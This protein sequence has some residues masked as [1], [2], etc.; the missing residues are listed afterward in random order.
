MHKQ[1]WDKMRHLGESAIFRACEFLT[2][3]LRLL[4]NYLI[5][6]RHTSRNLKIFDLLHNWPIHTIPIKRIV[7]W[8]LGLLA[9]HCILRVPWSVCVTGKIYSRLLMSPEAPITTREC[10][11]T[12]DPWAHHGVTS[13]P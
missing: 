3:H 8:A 12:K 2:I 1:H 5:E 7:I 11:T 4:V 13:P 6:S 9:M 10:V